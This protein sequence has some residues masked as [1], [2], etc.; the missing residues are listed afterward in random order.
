MSI[1]FSRWC[2]FTYC[3]CNKKHPHIQCN[4]EIQDYG[5]NKL[6]CTFKHNDLNKRLKLYYKAR[7]SLLLKLNFDNINEAKKHFDKIK[8]LDKLID[9]SERILSDE[10]DML[11]KK[12]YKEIKCRYDSNCRFLLSGNCRYLHTVQKPYE[13]YSKKQQF[14]QVE[15]KKVKEQ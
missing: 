15:Q 3:K 7:P 4:L 1:N 12:A 10:Q 11:D 8:Y 9:H 6:Y 2:L 5:C 14:I 13:L